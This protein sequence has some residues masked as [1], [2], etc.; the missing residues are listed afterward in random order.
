[1]KKAYL[2]KND[3]FKVLLGSM[4]ASY[5][6]DILVML[7]QPLIGHVAISLY[8]TLW[9]EFKKSSYKEIFTHDELC[10]DMGIDID[11]V[12]EGRRKL[13]AIGLLETYKE[14]QPSNIILYTYKM[15]APKCPKDFFDDIILKGLLVSKIGEKRTVE[16]SLIL[17]TKEDNLIKSENITAKFK[18]V[19]EL[20]NLYSS[21]VNVTLLD[22][23]GRKSLEIAKSFSK[24]EFISEISSRNHLNVNS[25]TDD[26]ID[27]VS[28]IAT[29]FGFNL[30]TICDLVESLYDPN[31]IPHLD[32]DLL[33]QRSL[34][35][36]KNA[37]LVIDS[38]TR[39]QKNYNSNDELSLLLNLMEST[40]PLEYLKL[41]QGMTNP[42]PS[43]VNII[44]M[45]SRD[46]KLHNSV[47]NAL[48]DYTLKTQNN[49]LP[50]AYIEKVA[51]SL[52]RENVETAFATINYLDRSRRRKKKSE[53]KINKPEDKEIN[54]ENNDS[55]NVVDIND[56][57]ESMSDDELKALL[58][59]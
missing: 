55:N 46:Y 39:E 27:E 54:V 40:S 4:L 41:K 32:Y 48:I 52:K 26:D 47:I 37:S 33:Y 57:V 43:D 56:E 11:S 29:L 34:E 28:R 16:L 14:I 10:V 58:R 24:G 25:L 31:N 7:Y 17:N 30:L 23:R 12:L 1:M 50:R 13:E 15:F 3:R 53:E 35:F 18:D 59:D 6:K 44:N 5:D 36:S 21:D 8:F 22:T 38:K 49:T 51:S 9:G 20:P 42:S 45:L 2:S 19:Y